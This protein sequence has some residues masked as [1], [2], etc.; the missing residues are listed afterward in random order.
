MVIA[1]LL[2]LPLAAVQPGPIIIT[3]HVA[4]AASVMALF[5][6]ALPFS[7]EMIAL[8]AMPTRVYGTFTSLEPAVATLMGL[9]LLRELPTAAQLAG[10]AAVVAASVGTAVFGA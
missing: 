1:A 6:S 8:T 5:S 4:L 3:G 9:M 2:I 10:I 7:L